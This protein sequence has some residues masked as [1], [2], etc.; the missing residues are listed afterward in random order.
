MVNLAD[1][2]GKITYPV[3]LIDCALKLIKAIT[4]GCRTK[5][6]KS[7]IELQIFNGASPIKFNQGT[8]VCPKKN[9]VMP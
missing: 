6:G 9:Q 7:L 2:P 4:I 8:N 1:G 5:G 3:W